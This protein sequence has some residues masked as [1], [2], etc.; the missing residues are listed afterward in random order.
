MSIENVLKFIWK[1]QYT[2]LVEITINTA[3]STA[4]RNK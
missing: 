3:E 2:G 1:E 4:V